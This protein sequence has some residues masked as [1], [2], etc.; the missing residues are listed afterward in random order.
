MGWVCLYTYA[1]P[2]VAAANLH[3]ALNA[4]ECELFEIPAPLGALDEGMATTLAVDF[5][6]GVVNAP[7]VPGTGVA[8]DWEY[9]DR[10]SSLR[11]SAREA[12]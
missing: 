12:A 9:V 7:T 11:I 5:A 4:P 8:V 1:L 3:I 2:P 6:A 10:N